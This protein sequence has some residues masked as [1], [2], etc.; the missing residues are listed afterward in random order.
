MKIIIGKLKAQT[1]FVICV[2]AF[3]LMNQK[4]KLALFHCV[5]K[6]HWKINLKTFF[7]KNKGL[8]IRHFIKRR[9]PTQRHSP[10]DPVVLS[11]LKYGPTTSIVVERSFSGDKHF[12]LV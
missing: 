11:F 4:K 5:M 7:S 9:I 6:Y 12:F 1:T 8:Q 2:I 10:H 3:L